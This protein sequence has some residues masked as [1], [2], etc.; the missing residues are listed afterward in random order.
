MGRDL[1][2][3]SNIQLNMCE[4]RKFLSEPLLIPSGVSLMTEKVSPHIVV[5]AKYPVIF[6]GREETH[7]LASNKTG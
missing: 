7:D 5:E 1:V 2:S 6:F 3:V 4:I